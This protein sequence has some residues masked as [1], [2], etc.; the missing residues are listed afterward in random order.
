MVI[1]GDVTPGEIFRLAEE[2]FAAAPAQEPPPAIRTVEPEQQGV[3]RVEV[4]AAAQTP[5]LHM[6]FHS[7]S[8]ADRESLPMSLLLSILSDGESSR[9]HRA[10]VEDEGLAISV[11]GHLDEGFDPGL[12]YFYLTLP[13]G[14][15]PA[16]VERRVL[17]E[18]LRAADDGVTDAELA[19]ARNIMLADY[20]RGLATIDGKA[21][22]LGQYEVFH[23]NYEKLFNLP[24]ALE[25][26]TTNDLRHVAA[27][28]FRARNM[29]VGVLRSAE[30]EG[31]E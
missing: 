26:V 6:A 9:L 21:E 30:I 19:K 24:A 31:A 28:V 7:G 12:T 16:V 17:A 13:P 11:G 15:D 22:I 2:Y 23:G 10:L 27:K 18:L 14:G 3:R 20:W 29:T 5:L 1:T 25:A 4:E 8:A